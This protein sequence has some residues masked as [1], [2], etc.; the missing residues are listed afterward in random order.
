MNTFFKWMVPV[1]SVS[2]IGIGMTGCNRSESPAETQADVSRAKADGIED[3]AKEQQDAAETTMEAQRDVNKAAI[4]L[5]HESVEGRR[6]V[7]LAEAE[8][9][10][11]VSIEKCE[12]MTGGARSDCKKQAD[13]DLA[14]AK[15]VAESI[16][17]ATDPK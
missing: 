5:E 14:A 16:A 13:A 6:A 7:A 15:A 4:E 3:V 11:K 2:A 1:L 8:A 17:Q 12:A 9:A 10:H